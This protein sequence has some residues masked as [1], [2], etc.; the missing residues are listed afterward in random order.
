MSDKK[1]YFMA[2]RKGERDRK[3]HPRKRGRESQTAKNCVSLLGTYVVAELK[4]EQFWAKQAN[5][6]S[7][8]FGKSSLS[9]N[10]KNTLDDDVSISAT[11]TNRRETEREREGERERRG[12]RRTARLVDKRFSPFEFLSSRFQFVISS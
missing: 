3:N 2:N 11:T 5:M 1:K 7:Y 9:K 8:S 4:S 6:S 10:K 12:R